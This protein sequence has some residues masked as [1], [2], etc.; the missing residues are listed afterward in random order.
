MTKTLS[1]ARLAPVEFQ[2]FRESGEIMFATPME[3]F[4][5]AFP[6]HYLR[7]IKRV[8]TSVIALIPPVDGIHATLATTGP[9]RVV[10][11]GD[12]FQNVPIRRAPEFIALS[13]PT[14]ATGVFELDPQPDMLLPFEGSGVAMSWE[15]SM[16]KAANQLD[17][18]AIADVLITLEY[19][20]LHDPDYR[21]QVIQ[22]LKP[23][24]SADRPYSLRSEF[25]DQWY[26]LHNPGQ[27]STPMVVRFATAR[28]DFPPNVDALKIQH[29]LL[30]FV[31]ADVAAVEV[32]V[33]HLHY[34]EAGEPGAVGGSATAI[35]GIISTRRGNAGSWSA[36]IG[37]S[38]IGEWELALP[39]T[40]IIRSRFGDGSSQQTIDDILLVVTYSGRTPEWPA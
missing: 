18:S 3:L 14:N 20:A 17:Y 35:D 24:I 36:I 9:S 25:A 22:S 19:T 37:K 39:D 5:R 31:C 16:P 15:F 4:D 21:Q 27:T 6:G 30:Y 11:G 32:V 26:D 8:R 7:L 23:T 38:P 12:V 1:L 29:V 34:T 10:I 33:S 40:D 28:E 13:A 2:R